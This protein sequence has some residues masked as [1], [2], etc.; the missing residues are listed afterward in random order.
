[1]PCTH[2]PE[3]APLVHARGS[4]KSTC[5]TCSRIFTVAPS[6]AARG[7]GVT[8]SAACRATVRGFGYRVRAFLPGTVRHVA[9]AGRLPLDCVRAILGKMVRSGECHVASFVPNPDASCQGAPTFMP[10]IALGAPADPDTPRDMRAAVTWHTNGLIIK[11]MPASVPD[12]ADTIGMP[13]TSVLRAVKALC[14]VGKC[15]IG[16]WK[17]SNRGLPTAIYHAGPGQDVPCTIKKLTQNQKDRRYLAKMKGDS[18]L[19]HAF[20]K[21]KSL[22]RARYWTD[23]AAKGDSLINALFGPRKPASQQLGDP[24]IDMLQDQS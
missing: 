5:V 16:G 19:S 24:V 17:R 21:R 22:S 7:G 15:H 18:S 9:E 3:A 11:A 10:I 1:M 20:D 4:L 13:Q 8:C 6:K 2:T 14:A 23:K 12:I